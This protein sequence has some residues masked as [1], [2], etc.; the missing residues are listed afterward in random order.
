MHP[1]N[2]RRRH[3]V[4]TLALILV[5]SLVGR[6]AT[7]SVSAP[8]LKAAFLF[9]FVK[10]AEWPVDAVSS[11]A[12]LIL[13]VSDDQVATHLNAVIKGHPVG[14]HELIVK[15]ISAES[16]LRQC[17]LVYLSGVD[18]AQS[19]VAL[20]S[21]NESP[22]LTVSDL[23]GFA[24]LGGIVALVVDDEKLRFV[25]NVDAASRARLSLSSKLLSLA[26]IVRDRPNLPLR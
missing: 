22:A 3:C 12:P 7:L 5:A 21:L 14:T 25:I 6:A 15:R 18:A 24:Q 26:S 10:F 20:Q 8:A 13:C 16:G 23:P 2:R 11:G 1:R 9:N 17:H 19:K 4:A